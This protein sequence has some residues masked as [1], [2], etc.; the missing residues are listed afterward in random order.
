VVC[1]ARAD[2][3][4]ERAARNG[5]IIIEEHSWDEVQISSEFAV[6]DPEV[7]GSI[8]KGLGGRG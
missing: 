6:Y 1:G 5:E 7:D 4:E 8:G 2:L 3:R